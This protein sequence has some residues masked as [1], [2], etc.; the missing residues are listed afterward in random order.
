MNLVKTKI[1]AIETD[2]KENWDGDVSQSVLHTF[3]INLIHK[4]EA[5]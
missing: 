3:K 4:S 2:T 1:E 5:R